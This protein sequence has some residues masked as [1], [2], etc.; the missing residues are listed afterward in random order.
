MNARSDAPVP[1]QFLHAPTALERQDAVVF[2]VK[3]C[4]NYHPLGR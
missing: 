2:Q 3:Q 1:A 4:R